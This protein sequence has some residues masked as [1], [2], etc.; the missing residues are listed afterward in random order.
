MATFGRKL[1]SITLFVH[2]RY[3]ARKVLCTGLMECGGVLVQNS[4]VQVTPT[5]GQKIEHAALSRTLNLARCT[6]RKAPSSSHQPVWHSIWR[7]PTKRLR[8]QS[9]PG[10]WSCVVSGRSYVIAGSFVVSGCC[11]SVLILVLDAGYDMHTYGAFSHKMRLAA[12][13]APLL[14]YFSKISEYLT[15]ADI[16]ILMVGRACTRRSVS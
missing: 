3:G 2:A 10:G 8:C 15:V 4:K 7:Y 13:C 16:R 12:K 1:S 11:A 5:R 9:N 6:Q 14:L